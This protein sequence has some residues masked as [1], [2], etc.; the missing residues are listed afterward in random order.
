MARLA[1]S[2]AA[3]ADLQVNVK[4]RLSLSRHSHREC[5]TVA[6]GRGEA[7][8][9]VVRR[10]KG[11]ATMAYALTGIVVMATVVGS[12]TRISAWALPIGLAQPTPASSAA[13]S[14]IAAASPRDR[15][16]LLGVP[17]LRF[18]MRHAQHLIRGL[19]SEESIASQL[20]WL[21]VRTRSNSC[22]SC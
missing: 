1:R 14:S 16:F 11:L 7:S 17:A 2:F 20:L 22:W 5:Q 3:A 8:R 15:G 6:H 18:S 10:R 9:S 4:R 13:I 19:L 12:L 21:A